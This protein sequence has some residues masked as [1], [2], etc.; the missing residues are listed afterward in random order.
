MYNL[1]IDALNHI[2]SF[3]D[4]HDMINFLKTSKK[5][6]AL[7][8]TLNFYNVDWNENV[9]LG[10]INTIIFS[11]K[12]IDL[13]IYPRL[14]KVLLVKNNYCPKLGPSVKS[15]KMT[16]NDSFIG[17][18]NFENL[19]TLQIPK[20]FNESIDNLTNLK[21]VYFRFEYNFPI[22]LQLEEL[23]MHTTY[24]HPI[25]YV[26]SRILC[27]SYNYN[28]PLDV[29]P[30]TMEKLETSIHYELT[31]MPK[32]IKYLTLRKY[33]D[34]SL[35]SLETLFINCNV[36]FPTSKFPPTLIDLIIESKIIGKIACPNLEYLNISNID[37]TDDIIC[38]KLKSFVTGNFTKYEM[39]PQLEQLSL[40]N[41]DG[42]L[43]NILPDT[44]EI[45][46]II[47]DFDKPLGKLPSNL[48]I[49]NINGIFNQPLGDLPESLYDLSII[50]NF[51]QPLGNLPPN[52]NFLNLGN[53]FNQPLGDLPPNLK[54]LKLG[55]GF[56][57]YSEL[58]DSISRNL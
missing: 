54:S 47:S 22:N 58:Y 31:Y 23:Y 15:F 16:L 8:D 41:F 17:L 29:L 2:S 36:P 53:E 4:G 20:G 46:D 27:M 5:W 44:L 43:Y 21:I 6:I 3:L 30:D 48:Q 40:I 39:F 14:N 11:D 51:N 1:Y 7:K 35:E 50:G 25:K 28:H 37:Y 42:D 55:S 32:K 49:L 26:P 18:Y 24:N 56:D 10:I 9:P 12:F 57:H 33:S 13:S 34:V 38:P 52:L 45:L 19:H